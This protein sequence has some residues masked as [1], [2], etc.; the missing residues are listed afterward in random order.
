MIMKNFLRLSDIL[1]DCIPGN[2]DL[3]G[4]WE[5]VQAGLRVAGLVSFSSMSLVCVWR[6]QRREQ[7]TAGVPVPPELGRQCSSSS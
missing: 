7:G 4:L 5:A 2:C 6:G 3:P 1:V